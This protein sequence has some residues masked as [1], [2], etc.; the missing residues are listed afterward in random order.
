M[1]EKSGISWTDAT[2]NPWLGCTKVGPGCDNCYAERLVDTRMHRAKW[3]PGEPRS[4]TSHSNWR[5]VE[6][7]N[8]DPSRLIG[9]QWPARK[10]RVFCASLADVFDNEI[11]PQW[12]TDLWALIKRTPNLQW[13]I[14]TK[15]IGNAEKMLPPDWGGGY[16]N[17]MLLI[18]VV[19][20][21]EADRDVPKLVRTPAAARG[22]S[23]EPM[24][25]LIDLEYP[26]MLWPDGPPMCCSGRDCGCRG[27][28]IEPPMIWKIDW[29]ICGG[30]SGP[31]ARPAHPGWFRHLRGQC[32]ANGVPFHHK[33]NGEWLHES[34]TTGEL[35]EFGTVQAAQLHQWDDDTASMRVGKER[36]GRLLDGAVHD[37][38]PTTMV[39]A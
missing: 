21:P 30:E 29:V 33:Q 36:S 34:Q 28:P 10:P 11:D 16:P 23:I 24:L 14:V 2:F 39:K 25:G 5:K 6:L 37:G 9:S 20:Q 8:E 15:R 13:L 26:E 32:A 17:V 27:L 3:G 7:W 18:T 19:N 22:L 4:R 38:F 35:L 1:A 31:G 12:R